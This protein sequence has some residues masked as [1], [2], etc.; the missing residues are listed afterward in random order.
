MNYFGYFWCIA[1]VFAIAFCYRR[2]ALVALI[3]TVGG[4]P[5]VALSGAGPYTSIPVRIVALAFVTA[6]S[7]IGCIAVDA[8]IRAKKC[9]DEISTRLS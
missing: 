4:L 5:Y 6:I 7:V 3:V 2:P 1:T 9:E 8:K